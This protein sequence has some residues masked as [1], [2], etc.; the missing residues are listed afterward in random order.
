MVGDGETFLARSGWGGFF[1][2]WKNPISPNKNEGRRCYGYHTLSEHSADLCA[3]GTAGV[4]WGSE[5]AGSIPTHKGGIMKTLLFTLLLVLG[6][7]LAW[8]ECQSVTIN[9]E[10]K[11]LCDK[12]PSAARDIEETDNWIPLLFDEPQRA[13]SPFP[14]RQYRNGEMDV[15]TYNDGTTCVSKDINGL[16]L[17]QVDCY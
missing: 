9:G 16:G 8:A 7:T 14:I 15:T 17:M 2:F 10:E 13:R 3:G 4:E 6:A 5:G 12:E 1:V 11:L